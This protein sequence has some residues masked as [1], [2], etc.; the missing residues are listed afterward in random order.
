MPY[1]AFHT[2][3]KQATWQGSAGEILPQQCGA[4]DE[5]GAGEGR[6]RLTAPNT[7][8]LIIS[9]LLDPHPRAAGKSG[10][11]VNILHSDWAA[12]EP[13]ALGL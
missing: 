12:S 9:R 3:Q 4:L 5:G 6:K 7:L 8:A 11:L 2:A 13:A 1:G 10:L